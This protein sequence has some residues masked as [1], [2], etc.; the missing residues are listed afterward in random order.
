L[1]E[2][3]LDDQGV[4][5]NDSLIE[6]SI[7][8]AKFFSIHDIYQG[9]VGNFNH[10]AAIMSITKKPSLLEFILSSDQEKYPVKVKIKA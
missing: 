3:F 1:S 9:W 5:P 4:A 7:H 2:F 10:V 6:S 8:Y